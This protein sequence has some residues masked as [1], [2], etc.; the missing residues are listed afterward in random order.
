MFEWLKS[1]IFESNDQSKTSSNIVPSVMPQA[2]VN[3][4]EDDTWVYIWNMTAKN[5]V[6]HAAIQVGGSQPKMK[7]EDPGEYISIHPEGIPAVGPTTILPLRA[8]L[9]KTLAEDMETQ[10][11]SK[12]PI[13]DD[14]DS[15]LQFRP[16]QGPLSS[17]P[18]QTIKIK[19]LDTKTML[20]QIDQARKKV[21]T[22]GMSYQLL[23]KINVWGFFQD[24]PFFI[25]QD[26]LDV[27]LNRKF[28]SKYNAT[29]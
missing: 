26:P 20:A 17:P 9:A 10:A 3:G 6:G 5:G 11:S 12:T 7:S 25:N 29:G 1:K 18:D 8:Q 4:E 22:G 19:N 14:F 28:L 21:K 13:I 2:V 16:K 23:P 27:H 15:P 24:A